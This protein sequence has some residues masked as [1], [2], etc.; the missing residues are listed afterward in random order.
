MY[1]CQL[2]GIK[3]LT[4]LKMLTYTLQGNLFQNPKRYC[5]LRWNAKC[6][7]KDALWWKAKTLLIKVV[8]Y[9]IQIEIYIYIFIYYLCVN[10][11]QK[12][13]IT[14]KIILI[15]QLQHSTKVIIRTQGVTSH[16]LLVSRSYYVFL[17]F[18]T[19]KSQ[20]HTIYFYFIHI[21]IHTILALAV[22]VFEVCYISLHFVIFL[23]KMESNTVY[24]NCT[25]RKY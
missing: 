8:N 11:V 10:F 2:K 22:A 23:L 20:I 12:K 15:G 9:S 25:R 19:K 5:L 21:L 14:A 13:E 16:S 6:E 24:V 18:T 17:Q 4:K 1:E 7:K 3:N